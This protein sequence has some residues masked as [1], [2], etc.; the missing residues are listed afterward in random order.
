M[1]QRLS[2]YSHFLFY[3]LTNFQQQ[4]YRKLINQYVGKFPAKPN[5]PEF[6]A[7]SQ[8]NQ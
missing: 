8:K 2:F 3:S 7:K 5:R 4:Q 1:V 6:Y